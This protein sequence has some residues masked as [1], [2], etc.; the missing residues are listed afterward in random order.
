MAAGKTFNYFCYTWTHIAQKSLISY[1]YS[2]L[3]CIYKQLGLQGNSQQWFLN[4]QASLQWHL[5]LRTSLQWYLK[6]HSGPK[7]QKHCFIHLTELSNEW[8]AYHKDS[9]VIRKRNTEK[10]IYK[11]ISESVWQEW[12]KL[13]NTCSFFYSSSTDNAATWNFI[14]Y[15]HSVKRNQ[16]PLLQ[17]SNQIKL[18]N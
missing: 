15:S 10:C 2:V 4:I 1:H 16:A 8:P 6:T 17:V 9:I 7:H 3:L 12:T 11:L 13:N 14:S 5:K 18:Y